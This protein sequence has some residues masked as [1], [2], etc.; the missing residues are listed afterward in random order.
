MAMV[1]RCA[2]HYVISKWPHTQFVHTQLV[3]THLVN[4]Q[5]VTRLVHTQLSTHNL[6]KYNL[7]THNLSTHNLS[8]HN[9]LHTTCPHTICPHTPCQH[10]SCHNLSTHNCLHTTCP[11][12]TCLH[13]TCPHTTVY[14][15]LVHRHNLSTHTLST[16][17]LS[18]IHTICP[19]TTCSHTTCSQLTH[20]QL[21]HTQFAH[22]QFVHARLAHTPLLHRKLAPTQLVHTQLSHTQLDN[23]SYTTY[24]HTQL[25]NRHFAW[26]AW[27]LAT[28]SV[29]LR[30]RRGTWRHGPPLCVAGVAL[31]ALGWLWWRAWFPVDTVDATAVCVAG[32]HLAT[33]SVTLRGRRGTWRHG[34][35]LCVAGV[36]LMALGWLWWRAWFLVGAGRRRCLRGRR[37]TWR[38]RA[39][40]CVAGVALTMQVDICNNWARG[41]VFAWSSRPYS[42]KRGYNCTWSTIMRRTQEYMYWHCTRRELLFYCF[43]TRPLSP[44]LPLGTFALK[45]TL[46]VWSQMSWQDVPSLRFS[47]LSKKVSAVPFSSN[48]QTHARQQ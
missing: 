45:E 7:S 9:C 14:T 8:T 12:T 5:V 17:K 28:S 23:F 20:T 30:G 37:G 29:T 19:H 4:M 25:D 10:A 48:G 22:T 11:H 6:S 13:T 40:L 44:S 35:P 21:V 16:C 47:Q 26:P 1:R 43:V 24:S 2:T 32:L 36:A 46:G 3:H 18:H 34:P 41:S 33:S 27:H 31:M 39:S 15:Q 38:H 42:T